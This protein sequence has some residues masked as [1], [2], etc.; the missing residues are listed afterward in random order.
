LEIVLKIAF[1]SGGGFIHPIK[2]GPILIHFDSDY[3]TFHKFFSHIKTELKVQGNFIFG[4]DQEWA[5]CKAAEDVFPS[6]IHLLCS[7]HLEANFNRHLHSKIGSEK[8]ADIIARMFHNNSC[9]MTSKSE[10]EFSDRKYSI[11]ADH[12]EDLPVNYFEKFCDN[13]W[14]KSV[15]PA[16]K[17]D[18]VPFKWLNNNSESK[19]HT[20]KIKSEWKSLPL[21]TL[22]NLIRGLI[23]TEEE[24]TSSALFGQGNYSLAPEVKHIYGVSAVCWH[25]KTPH[26]KASLLVKLLKGLQRKPSEV[27]SVDGLFRIAAKPKIQKKPRQV[28]SARANR[29]QTPLKGVKSGRVQKKKA[30]PKKKKVSPQKYMDIDEESSPLKSP[31]LD[32]FKEIIEEKR[33]RCAPSRLDL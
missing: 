20:F 24:D 12:R 10:K 17:H 33:I 15:E 28:D 26:Q 27:V 30:S 2:T 29:T 14:K 16:I 11:L 23:K 8:K 13:V 7:R 6:G 3:G 4:S 21:P 18:F 32:F 9:L 19:N 5:I 1:L 31:T 22:V 25:H